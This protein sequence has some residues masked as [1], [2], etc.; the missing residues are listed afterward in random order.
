MIT[1]SYYDYLQ[2]NQL[3][4]H[5]YQFDN[6]L[7]ANQ[8]VFPHQKTEGFLSKNDR[9]LDWGCGNGHFSCFLNYLGIETAG[10]S[11]E[12]FPKCMENK[13]GYSYQ[14]AGQAEP[15]KIDFPEQ[16]FDAVFSIGVLEHVHETGGDQVKSLK[17]IH[18]ILKDDGRFYCFHLPNKYSWVEAMV[19]LVYKFTRIKG[20]QP[21]SKKFSKRDVK[22]LCA[23]SGLKLIEYQRY[24]FLP[25]NLTKRLLPGAVHSRLFCSIFEKTDWLLS[26]CLPLFCNQ[27]YF[28]A[29]KV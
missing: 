15:V 24:N 25:R 14:Q 21:H 29:E 28:Y 2:E 26:R 16:N 17:E 3:L 5:L 19:N 6:R 22:Q 12:G 1:K 4:Q 9:V 27:S 11:F 18:R 8:Y 7:T 20:S 23:A 13:S 10:F